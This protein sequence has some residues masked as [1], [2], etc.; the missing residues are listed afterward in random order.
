MQQTACIRLYDHCDEEETAVKL[1]A[2]PVCTWK[3]NED[4][5]LLWGL[6]CCCVWF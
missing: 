1:M 6:R 3:K 2:A 4:E 5:K